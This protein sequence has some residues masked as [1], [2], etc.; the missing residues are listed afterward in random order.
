MTGCSAR[1]PAALR[2]AAHYR[3]R[4][5]A[6]ARF[7]SASPITSSRRRSLRGCRPIAR[8]EW[9][10]RYG[11]TASRHR[12]ADGRQP[13]HTF[14]YPWDQ[15]DAWEL[16][17]SQICAQGSESWS[18]SPSPRDD[19]L[20]IAPGFI[21]EALRPPRCRLSQ[22]LAERTRRIRICAR[23]LGAGQLTNGVRTELL[24]CQRRDRELCPKRA[25]SPTLPFR[26]GRKSPAPHHQR[27]L[28][29][30]RRPE[31]PKWRSWAGRQPPACAPGGI[32]C[33][34][35]GPLVPYLKGGLRRPGSR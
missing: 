26:P 25:A 35:Q 11:E 32:C 1:V 13:Q 9:V 22:L 23:K 17:G 20:Q 15:H 16:M 4:R 31:R 14:F 30:D 3:R 27:H 6:E 8:E 18:C 33:I 12:D 5:R 7:I 24:R 29:R 28:L 19:S 2:G 10:D 34:V 21:R